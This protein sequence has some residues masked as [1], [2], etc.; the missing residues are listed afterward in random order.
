MLRMAIQGRKSSLFNRPGSGEMSTPTEALAGGP[1]GTGPDWR[2]RSRTI[3]LSTL[4]LAMTLGWLAAAYTSLD[5]VPGNGEATRAGLMPSIA[6]SLQDDSGYASLHVNRA[7]DAAFPKGAPRFTTASAMKG[8]V[9][10]Q[11]RDEFVPGWSLRGP[12]SL[13][14]QRTAN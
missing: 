5:D 2:A 6:S 10:G 12:A 3:I 7:A 9:A 1:A 14:E 4:A 8:A 11:E 13:N